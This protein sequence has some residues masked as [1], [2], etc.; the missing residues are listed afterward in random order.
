[1][2]EPTPDQLRGRYLSRLGAE[3]DATIMRVRDCAG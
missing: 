1:M 3:L 2:S